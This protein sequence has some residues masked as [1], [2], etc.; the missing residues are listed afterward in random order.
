M[1]VVKVKTKYA[2]SAKKYLSVHTLIDNNYNVLGSNYFIYFPIKS[3]T[4]KELEILKKRFKATIVNKKLEFRNSNKSYV[5]L[6]KKILG[7]KFDTAPRGF[8][9]LGSLAIIDAEKDIAKKIATVIFSVNTNIKT[10][11][12][13]AGSVKGRYRKRTYEYVA[14]DKT[15]D[16]LYRENGVVLK[17]D[18]RDT[19]FSTRLA[20]ERKR[21]A[22]LSKGDE[23][24]IVM[25]AGV[26]PFAIEIAKHNKNSKVVAIEINRNA[27]RYMKEN[28]KINKVENVIALSG[29]VNKKILGYKNFAD[30]IVMPL[31]KDSGSFLDAVVYAASESCIVHYYAFVDLDGGAKEL[32]NKLK[33]FFEKKNFKFESVFIR[34]VRPYSPN[35]IEIVIDFKI[36][37]KKSKK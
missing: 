21:I 37:R 9:I 17:F 36:M 24:V 32:E 6:L 25:F 11:V 30:R 18:L 8:E 15:F 34:T 20:F 10:V 26:G 31:P 16:V 7:D 19:F 35:I 12:R 27:V 22:T 23:N 3:I 2:E 1:L 14:G 28:I 5:E 33:T 29:D 13:K 4:T